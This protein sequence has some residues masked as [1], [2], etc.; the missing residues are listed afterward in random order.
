MPSLPFVSSDSS[1][2]MDTVDYSVPPGVRLLEAVSEESETS[3]MSSVSI[4]SISLDSP[5][6]TPNGRAIA[7]GANQQ[8]QEEEM[9]REAAP[10]PPPKAGKGAS[11]KEEDQ[12]EPVPS[13]ERKSSW[14]DWL[15]LKTADDHHQDQME[16][17][18]DPNAPPSPAISDTPSTPGGAGPFPYA[19]L[20]D[21]APSRESTSSMFV[22]QGGS[23]S[24]AS[25]RS[26]QRKKQY[27][28]TVVPALNLATES[29]R[30]KKRAASRRG[31]LIPLHSTLHAQLVAIAHEYKLPSTDDIALYLLST[32]DSVKSQIPTDDGPRI[33]DAAWKVLW[34]EL[35]DEDD[36]RG[37]SFSST[38]SDDYAS[39]A[40]PAT[41]S[42]SG[43]LFGSYSFF[44]GSIS[45]P[46]PQGPPL[47]HR[48]NKSTPSSSPFLGSTRITSRRA[49]GEDEASFGTAIVVGRVEFDLE[50]PTSGEHE[51]GRSDSVKFEPAALA[52][53]AYEPPP[54]PPVHELP[55]FE[56]AGFPQIER[57]R[58]SGTSSDGGKKVQR[59][60]AKR[61]GSTK[62]LMRDEVESLP[63][64]LP[65]NA[66]AIASPHKWSAAVGRGLFSPVEARPGASKLSPSDLRSPQSFTTSTSASQLP[67]HHISSRFSSTTGGSPKPSPSSIGSEV[68]SP[69][70]QKENQSPSLSFGERRPSVSVNLASFLGNVKMDTEEV[71]QLAE[72]SEVQKAP[73]VGL[74]VFG[75][76]KDENSPEA[77]AT[78]S[79]S[80]SNSSSS[81]ELANTLDALQEALG[82]Q[83]ERRPSCATT[84]TTISEASTTSTNRSPILRGHFR[85]QSSPQNPSPALFSINELSDTRPLR[86]VQRKVAPPADSLA[87]PTIDEQASA[88]DGA[89]ATPH[90][91]STIS[92]RNSAYGITPSRPAPAPPLPSVAEPTTPPRV[93]T[94]MARAPTPPQESTT[95]TTPRFGRLSLDSQRPE[96]EELAQKELAKKEEEQPKVTPSSTPSSMWAAF[97]KF[98][99]LFGGSKPRTG[100]G[101]P[102]VL[103]IASPALSTSA[104]DL[105]DEIPMPGKT[106]RRRA[107]SLS[108]KFGNFVSNLPAANSTSSS[109]DVPPPIPSRTHS[110]RHSP[111]S[112]R[113]SSTVSTSSVMLSQNAISALTNTT[114]AAPARRGSTVTMEGKHR[115]MG[116]LGSRK[117]LESAD[118]GGGRP[119][120][121]VDFKAA[122]PRR[123]LPK[124]VLRAMI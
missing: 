111:A 107:K 28:L 89:S 78:L 42:Q 115:T 45:S 60:W 58:S 118:V 57:R 23:S 80:E 52:H 7:V 91:W 6:R 99:G 62:P 66:A 96:K 17:L 15:G 88:E 8:Q 85:S 69:L 49:S 43:G 87:V 2:R 48:R 46:Q 41:P 9:E 98:G 5:P 64:P 105:T 121:E 92:P 1:P 116:S 124:D 75:I 22:H 39:P 72:A 16:E 34:E 74:G 70:N 31:S 67:P 14:R 104:T 10:T 12:A 55:A 40:A 100:E 90:R 50:A 103:A 38:T 97:P 109:V 84:A 61:R 13:G 35:F 53:L 27:L 117:G 63:Q 44:T 123:E 95:S 81:L 54:P 25:L 101:S 33:G 11:P 83:H 71:E 51:R 59:D 56:P 114:S 26:R 30:L 65:P 120:F 110:G 73:E 18:A 82:F 106:P 93:P 113:S 47:H 68:Y 19:F 94:P 20:Q 29:P 122:E 86:R 76:T 24:T 37:E 119:R 32:T 4:R 21:P 112:S 102:E 36:G 79:S 3:S 77:P 108:K